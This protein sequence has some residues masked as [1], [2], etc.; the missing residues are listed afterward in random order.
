MPRDSTKQRSGDKR[1]P[2]IGEI[3]DIE[4]AAGRVPPQNLEAETSLLGSILIEKDAII[5]VADV[6]SAEDFYSER[7][8]LIYAAIMDLYEQRQPID[9]VSLSNKLAEASELE[10]IGGSAYVAELTSAVPTA[11]HVVHYA[12]I[13]SH[14]ATLRRLI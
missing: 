8:A 7:N 4:V 11:A 6:V 2:S 1:L 14:K 10:H 9:I 13:V 5:K 12:G 3:L